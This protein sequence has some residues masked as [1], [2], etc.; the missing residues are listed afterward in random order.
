MGHGIPWNGA[1][2]LVVED[3]DDGVSLVRL[4][5]RAELVGNPVTGAA[6]AR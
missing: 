5:Y 3:V 2:G 4:P 1:L 6:N